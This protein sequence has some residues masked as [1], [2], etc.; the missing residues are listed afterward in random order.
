MVTGTGLCQSGTSI[1]GCYGGTG[2]EPDDQTR[3][4]VRINKQ[5]EDELNKEKKKMRNRIKILLLGCGEAGKSTFIKQMRIIHSGKE[6]G[7]WTVEE[8][9]QYRREILMNVIQCIQILLEEMTGSLD[10]SLNNTAARL[11][12]LKPDQEKD[13]AKLW[14]YRDNIL[15]IWEEP[16]IQETFNRRNEF[17][18]P[19]CCRYFLTNIS[20]ISGPTFLPES[21][22]ILQIRVMTTG[23]IEYSFDM[24]GKECIM[25]DVGGQRTERKKWIHCFEDVLLV[26]FLAA[27]S[28]YDQVL[29]EDHT[30]NRME[31]SLNLFRTILSYHWFKNS[32][33]ALFLNKKDLL[34]EKISTSQLEKYFPKFEE[35]KGYKTQDYDSAMSFIKHM[36]HQQKK[37]VEASRDYQDSNSDGY[38]RSWF[39]HETMAT[40]TD[41]IK[42]VFGDVKKTIMDII[43]RPFAM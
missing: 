40:D 21:K 27:A 10:T 38:T 16:A 30:E 41:N 35:F 29:E 12:E 2:E 31:E 39:V 32:A 8:R 22:D 7:G 42:K 43:L 13:Q 14:E 33:I 25:I 17:N 36:F 23:V 18:L 11:K 4:S 37:D 26:M 9:E 24:D 15:A 6:E 28:E 3:D 5:I 20:R 34:K 1:L 19:D